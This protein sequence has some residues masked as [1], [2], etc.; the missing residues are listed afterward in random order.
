MLRQTSS[1]V[2]TH[3]DSVECATSLCMCIG[4]STANLDPSMMCV[5]VYGC[6]I[7]QYTRHRIDAMLHSD[8]IHMHTEC[9]S[10][11]HSKNTTVKLE[12]V[13]GFA[14]SVHSP[15]SF[16][17]RRRAIRVR[18]CLPSIRLFEGSG[19]NT[20]PYPSRDRHTDKT[21]T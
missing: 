2:D 12:T 19:A 21:Y 8:S 4:I 11:M 13:N 9:E 6:W 16:C 17:S 20:H 7:C 10:R 15:F 5:C 1:N 3:E 18:L 14:V